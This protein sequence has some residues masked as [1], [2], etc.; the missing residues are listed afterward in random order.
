MMTERKARH[1]ILEDRLLNSTPETVAKW[2][3]EE[4]AEAGKNAYIRDYDI[5]I[6]ATL[7]ATGNRLVELAIAEHG[8]NQKALTTLWE[9]TEHPDDKQVRHNKALRLAMLSNKNVGANFSL[10]AMTVSLIGHERFTTFIQTATPQELEA[11]CQNPEIEFLE[12]LYEKKGYF[13]PLS[14]ERWREVIIATIGNPRITVKYDDRNDYDGWTSYKRGCE[15]RAAY[16]LAATVPVTIE[17]AN[18]LAWLLAETIPELPFNTKVED[19]D[20]VMARWRV[21]LFPKYE[22]SNFHIDN[23]AKVRTFFGRLYLS[24]GIKKPIEELLSSSDQA[25]RCVAYSAAKLTAEQVKAGAEMDKT[26]FLDWAL[27]NENLCMSEPVREAVREACRAFGDEERHE[28]GWFNTFCDKQRIKHPHW[29]KDDP[30]KDDPEVYESLASSESPPPPQELLT[31][32]TWVGE[33]SK[34]INTIYFI[35]IVFAIGYVLRD[36]FH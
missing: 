9:K 19:I 25:T 34:K 28:G 22:D 4:N 35:V 32:I 18:C 12:S 27:H 20:A 14:E 1:M 36:I 6:E 15:P 3:K 13:E 7:L 10:G 31:L 26:E 33:L 29:F 5:E 11:I 2:I 30:Y 16:K 17:W 8:T 24:Y 23:C 21:N